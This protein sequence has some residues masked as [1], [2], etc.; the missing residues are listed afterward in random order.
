M[1][2]PKGKTAKRRQQEKAKKAAKKKESEEDEDEES[3]KK[4]PKDKGD[5]E[6]R[7]VDSVS[8][9]ATMEEALLKCW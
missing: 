9:S 8:S 5:R 7:L 3:N 6:H 4:K 1:E 2:L